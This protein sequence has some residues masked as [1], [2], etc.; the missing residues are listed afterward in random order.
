MTRSPALRA[1]RRHSVVVLVLS[2]AV[3]T[4][5]ARGAIAEI[6]VTTGISERDVRSRTTRIAGAVLQRA[7]SMVALQ[8]KCD[9]GGPVRISPESVGPLP[10]AAPLR[11]L[12]TICPGVQTVR[13]AEEH[14]Y[15]AVEFHVGG[16]TILASQTIESDSVK[17]DDP[18]D[19][20]EVKGTN[21]ILPMGVP[22][23]SRWADLRRAYGAAIGDIVFDEVVVR[24]CKFPNMVLHL[25]ADYETVRPIQGNDLSRI[26]PDSKIVRILITSWAFGTSRC[27]G[28]EG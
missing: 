25:D 12:L 15:P 26:P 4:V 8:S 21:G 10:V 11:Q 14:A 28:S 5:F 18:A 1:L 7:H 27:A 23:S 24:F 16:L 20:W 2:L 17:L 13:E 19:T 9:M 6:A 22:M 3:P